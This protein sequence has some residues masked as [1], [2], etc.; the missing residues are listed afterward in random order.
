ME[1]LVKRRVLTGI[2]FVAVA[3]AGAS[4]FFLRRAPSVPVALSFECTP[5]EAQ[6]FALRYL[7]EGTLEDTT[8]GLGNGKTGDAVK[9]R[10][11]VEGE[12][13]STCVVSTHDEHTVALRFDDATVALEMPSQASQK[14]ADVLAGTTFVTR[15]AHGRTKS[16]RFPDAMPE[17]GRNVVRDLLS[18]AQ[19]TLPETPAAAWT[20]REQDQSGA[21]DAAYT[22]ESTARESV[23]I[24]KERVV[25]KASD[26]RPRAEP[27]ESRGGIFRVNPVHHAVESADVTVALTLRVGD[28]TIGTTRAHVALDFRAT[29]RESIA[30]LTRELETLDRSLA[31][32]SDLAASDVDARLEQHIQERELCD[33]TWE[34]LLA[35]ASAPEVDR[36]K[37]FLK[38]KALFLLHPE[39]CAAA[40]RTLAAAKDPN[41]MSFLLVSGALT[42]AGTREA[43]KALTSAATS[44]VGNTPIERVL[45]GNLGLLKTPTDETVTM[46]DSVA[47]GNGDDES[48]GAARLARGSLAGEMAKTDAKSVRA[49]ALVAEEVRAYQNASANEDRVLALLA[50]GNAGSDEALAVASEAL[51]D[52]DPRV[53]L[54]AASSLR[55]IAAGAAEDLLANCAQS[56]DVSAVRAEAVRSLGYRVLSSPSLEI[57]AHAV[58]ADRD[59]DV[60]MAALQ[61]LAR[62]LDRDPAL[63]SVVEDVARDERASGVRNAA[64]MA[65]ERYRAT[66]G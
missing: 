56:D 47:H 24:R 59:E 21:Y 15:D 50:L 30:S 2:A 5:G 22:L 12:L 66:R 45:I 44:V 17:A 53:R 62:E 9:A 54:A 55:F 57:V 40:G 51:H 43:Q 65:M 28:K 48:R 52:A 7:S 19:I 32:P 26:K 33:D 10:A 31:A 60:R 58:K 29:T 6:S 46:L 11:R 13:V 23:A 20:A 35:K 18:L 38:L 49:S 8:F 14:P 63:A 3:A 41:A 4:A 36:A 61:V 16:I 1:R 37:A 64:K 34:S 42:S 27:G 39:S 25:A